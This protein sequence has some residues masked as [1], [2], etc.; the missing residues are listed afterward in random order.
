MWYFMWMSSH[1]VNQ[2]QILKPQWIGLSGKIAVIPSLFF[3]H[4]LFS[5]TQF[6][7]M[8]FLPHKEVIKSFQAEDW[9]LK[10]AESTNCSRQSL[11]PWCCGRLLV[12]FVWFLKAI[13]MYDTYH[14][15]TCSALESWIRVPHAC[16]LPFLCQVFLVLS[17]K[18]LLGLFTAWW[19]P[20]NPAVTHMFCLCSRISMDRQLPNLSLQN[21]LWDDLY[22]PV[23]WSSRNPH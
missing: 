2:L 11:G 23:L 9:T 17:Y 19:F 6:M 20:T 4:F 1:A 16:P 22:V 15:H 13:I 7:E 8:G 14:G 21:F 5:D 18:S 10:E 12:C 3:S